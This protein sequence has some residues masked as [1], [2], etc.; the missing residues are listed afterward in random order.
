MTAPNFRD[1][2]NYLLPLVRALAGR[3]PVRPSEIV[4]QVADLAGV[5]PD[6]RQVG[7]EEGAGREVYKNRIRFARQSLIDAGVLRGSSDPKWQRGRWELNAEGEE[8]ARSMTDSQLEALL[9]ERAAEGARARAMAR[10]DSRKLA[11]LDDEDDAVSEAKISEPSAPAPPLPAPSTL[12][13]EPK[14]DVD[15]IATIER[16]VDS[17]NEQVTTTMLEYVRGMPD[18]AFEHLVADVLRAALRAD[19]ARVTQQSRDGGIDGILFFDALQMRIAV[20]EAKRYADG[21]VVGRPKIDAFATAAR[22]RKAAHAIFVTSSSFSPEAKSAAKEE[23]VRLIDGVAFVE[24]MAEH[25]IGLRPRR[26]FVVYEVDPAW[27]VDE[28]ET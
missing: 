4:E 11:G 18:S 26:R 13:D 25:G 17:A 20:F 12:V 21:N 24:L 16:L 15:Q 14:T 3:G 10:K 5:S 2:R 9:L 27:A 8:L 22:R 1:H 7:L 6:E 19:S 23:G 28:D